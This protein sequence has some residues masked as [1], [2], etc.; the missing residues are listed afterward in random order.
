MNSKL[1]YSASVIISLFASHKNYGQKKSETI[2]SEVVNVVKPYTA[3]LSDAFKIKD[4]PKINDTENAKKIAVQYAIFSVPVAS[5]FS[6][7]KGT[8]VDVDPLKKDLLYQNY[9][10]IGLG[11]YKS[12]NIDFF[13]N[14]QIAINQ[15]F[16]V[17]LR[18]VSSQNGIENVELKHNFSDSKLDLAYENHQDQYTFKT[19][20][21][22][23]NKIY[24][25]Y[26]LPATFGNNL[27]ITDRQNLINS[28]NPTQIYN[29]VFASGTINF[30]D[31]FVKEVKVNYNYFQD[32][33]NSKENRFV[34]KTALE[35]LI[36]DKNIRTNVYVDHVSG[37][38]IFDDGSTFD[39]N[40]TNLGINPNYEI[41]KD[42]LTLNLG[43]ELVYNAD[44]ARDAND[45]FIYPKVNASYKLVSDYMIAFAGLDGGLQQNSYRNFVQHNPFVMP[46][47]T[48]GPTNAMYDLSIGLKGKLS[49]AMVYNVKASYLNENNKALIRSTIFGTAPNSPNFG[50]G[51]SFMI[52]YADVQ[53]LS[54]TGELKAKISESIDFSISGTFRNFNQKSTTEVWN[55]PKIELQSTINAKISEKWFCGASLF[56]VGERKD[57]LVDLSILLPEYPTTTLAGFFDVNC[58]LG[59]H[60]S[61]RLTTFL[62]ANNIANQ[63]YQR[64]LN[65]PVQQFQVILGA[66]YKFDF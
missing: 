25:W 63:G 6:P 55:I 33:Y 7:Q 20:I 53:T 3:T 21:G 2:E 12:A 56:Y 59:Y 28:M 15:Y 34:V 43:F 54:F 42:D 64:W 51:N 1:I 27:S 17:M 26:G 13:A 65:F 48:I 40:I 60:H 61:N 39:H 31:L 10:S 30:K 32:D 47:L 37:F 14:H 45:F 8:A 44:A 4:I 57:I 52:Q 38:S 5:T 36:F 23:E 50:F 29:G 49:S 46:N 22:F 66:A 19:N 58:N 16:G 35:N 11:S 62:K 9:L 41:K 18:H 24:N